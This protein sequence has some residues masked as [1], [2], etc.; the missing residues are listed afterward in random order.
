MLVIARTVLRSVLPYPDPLRR[1]RVRR[2]ARNLATRVPWPRDEAAVSGLDCARLALLRLLWLQQQTR[3]AVWTRQ[4][5]GAALL[6]R[7]AIETCILGLWCL[8]DTDAAGRLRRSEIKAAS[9]MLT[10]VSNTGVIPEAL[11]KQALG[12]LGEPEKLLDVRSMAGKIDAKTGA[13]LAIHLYDLAYRPASQYFAHAS[14][15]ALLRHVTAEQ[16]G[17]VRPANSWVRRAPIRLA[18]ACVGL[19]AGAIAHQV[20]ASTDLYMHYGEGHASRVLPPLLITIGKG[21]ARQV[22]VADVVRVLLQAREVKDYL[23]RTRPDEAPVEREAR[24]RALYDT[25][26]IRLNLDVPSEAIQ[27][28]VDHFVVKVLTEWDAEFVGRSSKPLGVAEPAEE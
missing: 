8:H 28:I 14:G 1:A 15:S 27:P 6:A 16:R 4:R 13:T 9:A 19:L 24:L 5:E 21:M 23:S 12:V 18:D 7:T 10:F 2:S 20:G 22:R 3:R 11:I 26:I 17:T 25:V